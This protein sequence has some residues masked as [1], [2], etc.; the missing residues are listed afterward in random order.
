M[1]P[2]W[3]SEYDEPILKVLQEAG[4]PLNPANI[5]FLLEY[6]EYATPHR[7]TRDRRLRRLNE[8]SFIEKIDD[9]P[10]YTISDKGRKYLAGELDA[11]EL[12]GS[13]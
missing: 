4:V 10:Y 12:E 13:E 1:Q 11:S 9:S 3:W 7:S 6:L 5:G 2:R 8:N